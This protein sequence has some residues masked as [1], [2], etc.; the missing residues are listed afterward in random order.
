MLVYQ[1]VNEDPKRPRSLVKSVPKD[2][3]TICLRAL[4]KDPNRRYQTALAVAEELDRYLRG[5]PILSRPIS[6]AERGWRLV[7]RRPLVSGLWLATAISLLLFV[8]AAWA[9]R[10][11]PRTEFLP[12]PEIVASIV[13]ETEPSAVETA[14]VPLSPF[15]HM[16]QPDKIRNLGKSPIHAKLPPGR[17]LVVAEAPDGRFHE[18]IRYVPKPE[19]VMSGPGYK[20][21]SFKWTARGEAQLPTVKIPDA[22]VTQDMAYFSGTKG[23]RMGIPGSPIAP[24]HLVDVAAFYLDLTELSVA[25]YR[26]LRTKDYPDLS[27]PTLI[28]A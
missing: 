7:R 21:R 13:L 20:Y 28:N 8:G 14:F 27:F 12:P 25:E 16:P 15:D 26:R 11:N 10:N 9:W 19:E 24:Q 2:L 18:V 6:R 22:D 17:Y 4:E 23:F 5:E 3:E 1:I